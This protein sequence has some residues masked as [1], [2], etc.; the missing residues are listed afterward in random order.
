MFL[1][2][3]NLPDYQATGQQFYDSAP[4][5]GWH[6]TY[7]F[8]KEFHVLEDVGHEVWTIRQTGEYDSTAFNLVTSFIEESKALQY[9]PAGFELGRELYRTRKYSCHSDFCASA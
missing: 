9:Q 7:Y 3:E 1:Y 2:G 6:S 5:E 8:H 4:S